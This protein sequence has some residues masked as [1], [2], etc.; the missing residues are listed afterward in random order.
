MRNSHDFGKTGEP[1]GRTQNKTILTG[2]LAA[3]ENSSVKWMPIYLNCSAVEQRGGRRPL[4]TALWLA[5]FR[6]YNEKQ[7]TNL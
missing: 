5:T 6:F 2:V 4:S 7:E 3:G 1:T